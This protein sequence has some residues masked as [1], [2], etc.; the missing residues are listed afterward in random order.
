[1]PAFRFLFPLAFLLA[2]VSLAPAQPADNR[3]DATSGRDLA[4]Y[5]RDRNFDHQHML[6][7]VD[8]PDVE[9]A[10]FNAR[11][12]W[13]VEAIGRP[14][15]CLVFDARATMRFSSVTS[16]GEPCTFTHASDLLTIDLPRP[17][18][19]G[20]PVR[21]EM[22][23]AAE[24]PYGS[25]G[26]FLGPTGLSWFK[27][28]PGRER[29]GAQ[30]YSQGQAQ[31]NS[32]WFPCHDF[33]NERVTSELVVTVQ[34]PYRV[35]SNG[36]LVSVARTGER[37]TYHWRQDKPHATYLV[38]LVVGLFDVV[39]LG[40]PG[41]KRP[42]LEMPVYAPVGAGEAARV[43]LGNTP[44]M[45][46]YLEQVLDEPYPWDKYAQTLVRNMPGGMEN[47]SATTMGEFAARSGPGGVDDLVVHELIHQWFGDLMTCRTWAHLWL[48]E[49]WATY[50]E[51][52]W[53]EH[54]GG[55]AGYLDAV[56]NARRR[57]V[58]RNR[59]T[60]PKDVPMVS[61]RYS[62]PE[63][64]FAKT[65]DVYAKGGLVLHALRARLGDEAF[66]K[67]VRAYIDLHKF[68]VVETDDFRNAM[69]DA[70]GQSLERFFHQYCDRAGVP[71][72][73]V[74]ATWDDAAKA[75]TVSVE[76]TQTINADN[77]AYA[78][79]VPI[80]VDFGGDQGQWITADTDVRSVE[81]VFALAR[82]PV[83][84]SVDPGVSIIGD[85]RTT[86]NLALFDRAR[87]TPASALSG[88]LPR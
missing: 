87:P 12:V 30:I 83:S 57:F 81:R 38:S 20:K 67:G 1:M 59:A 31:W 73:A 50:G 3:I 85:I 68:G 10:A 13:T 5:P 16:G 62:S 27:T 7:V 44:E 51:H 9:T 70:S 46:R 42:G 32:F 69:E 8:I 72:L 24:K 4:N 25:L 60:L 41:S 2:A 34:D 45:I 43:S 35:V 53:A 23:Y 88:A 86:A 54:Q 65:D 55:E 19:P 21:V 77:P 75:L 82:K 11:C 63:D 48:N 14:Q 64:V 29:L 78:L 28:R 74:K 49:G 61:N 71:V 6:L 18:V 22:R 84:I 80:Y 26:G 33:P 52:L 40:G 17:A 66:F 47:T 15:T 37:S 56:S 79:S 36:K 58:A 76:Q 39:T